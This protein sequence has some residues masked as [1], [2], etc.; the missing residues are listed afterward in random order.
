MRN[1][2]SIALI[3]LVL[4]F[5][6]VAKAQSCPGAPGWVFDDVQASDLFCPQITWLAERGIS[7]G[8]AVIDG[9]HRLYCPGQS[10]QRDQMAAFLSRLAAAL[11]PSSCAL[12]QTLRWNGTG[13][14]CTDLIAGPAGPPGP[15][16][17]AGA[18]GA[19]G[20]AGAA[21]TVAVGSVTT[22]T[23]GSGAA[24]TN[25]GTSSAAILNF[26]IP[27]GA[28]G[29]SCSNT[30]CDPATSTATITCGSS[31]PVTFA[32]I[33]TN[34]KRVFVSS[35]AFDGN[36][37]GIAGA[38][39]KCQN[40]AAAASLSGTWRAWLSTSLSTAAARLAHSAL[41]YATLDGKVVALNWSDLT[42]GTL[43]RPIA[44]DEFGTPVS[45]AQDVW[46]A[47]NGSGAYT[48]SSCGDFTG[49]SGSAVVGSTSRIDS[50]WTLANTAACG[51][52]KRL[53]CVQQ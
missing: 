49:T 32:C 5:V 3:A 36:L 29:A 8:C 2:T 25:V 40:T 10:V 33:V 16:G 35:T 38:D 37:G 41:P 4:A 45:S 30:A 27:Q 46:T 43:L 18:T 39:A 53:Y 44:A 26:T 51:A 23:P 42:D 15:Q 21:A 52:L 24:V 17:I 28:T 12:G 50:G 7:L 31:E 13:W 9:A 14:E 34:A 11:L 20:A 6:G 48:G 47:T 22:G 1:A 19:Q